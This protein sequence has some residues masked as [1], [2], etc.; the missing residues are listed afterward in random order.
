[1]ETNKFL[2]ILFIISSCSENFSPKPKGYF[3]IDFPKKNYKIY[4]NDCNYEFLIES[5]AKVKTSDK[6]CWINIYYEIFDAT[7]Y[8]TYK[9]INSDLNKILEDNYKLV[10]DHSI[11]SNAI[12][13][14]L[15]ENLETKSVL[16][17]IIGNTASNIQFYSTDSKNHFVRGSLYFNNKP[18]YDSIIPVKNFLKEDIIKLIE[19]IR[20][21]DI[22]KVK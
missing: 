18:N 11:K 5:N 14:K 9:K 19:S 8:I 6:N 3:R 13:E 15:Y 2:F 22:D 20:F 1:M 16:Y 12:N 4:T 7:I 10:F 17:E 21:T